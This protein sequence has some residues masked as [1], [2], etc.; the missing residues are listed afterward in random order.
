[1]TEVRLAVGAAT[2]PGLRRPVNEDS[3]LARSPGFVVADGMG[4][5]DAGDLASAAVVAAFRE[6]LPDSGLADVTHVRDALRDAEARV[7]ALS[8][9][10][11]RGAGST[12]AAAILVQHD[13]T[14]HWLVVNV[15]DSRVYRFAHGRLEQL[16]VDHSLGGHVITRAIGAADSL[17]DSWM[18]P[19]V[20]RERLLVCSDGVHSEVDDDGI[21]GLL[22][23]APDPEDAAR[24]LVEEA[25]RRGGR[26]NITALV[27]DV[28]AA[29]APT[30]VDDL[31]D[32]LPARR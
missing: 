17:A 25:K 9:G 26:D 21:R 10:T 12:V 1:M 22:A 28:V 27:V 24:A 30:V 7:G 16:T 20:T 13:G 3:H 31:D 8:A 2:D 6:A 32:T 5:H 18:L 15:G 19:V 11:P 4:G 29:P 14:P 23:A